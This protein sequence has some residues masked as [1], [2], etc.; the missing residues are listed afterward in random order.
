MEYIYFILLGILRLVSPD[1]VLVS[2]GSPVVT[3]RVAFLLNKMD[4]LAA[5]MWWTT[6]LQPCGWCDVS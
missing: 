3:Q 2:Y 1:N 6:L 5:T 4:D